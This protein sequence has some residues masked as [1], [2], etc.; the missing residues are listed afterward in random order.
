VRIEKPIKES[1]SDSSRFVLSCS[2]GT[3]HILSLQRT[4]R[5]ITG[6]PAIPRAIKA[7]RSTD[8]PK[9]AWITPK[10]SMETQDAR[11]KPTNTDHT[12]TDTTKASNAKA[13]P[14][15]GTH[16]APRIAYNVRSSTHQLN[17]NQPHGHQGE[18]TPKLTDQCAHKLAIRHRELIQTPSTERTWN[19]PCSSHQGAMR[20]MLSERP[21]HPTQ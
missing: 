9:P 20:T 12:H 3:T 6:S 19:T 4:T 16:S 2:V 11:F 14:H 7:R 13:Q 1:D 15:Q 8:D 21:P 5:V 18:P 10:L 17:P